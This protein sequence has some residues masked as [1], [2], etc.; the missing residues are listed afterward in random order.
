MNETGSS[1]SRAKDISFR[2]P[3][4]YYAELL[5][6]LRDGFSP[7]LQPQDNSSLW[8]NGKLERR[9]MDQIRAHIID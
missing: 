3:S 2:L 6:A 4:F 9:D 1:G 5:I 7:G 8:K